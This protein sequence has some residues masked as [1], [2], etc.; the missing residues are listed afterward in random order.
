MFLKALADD[1]M[2]PIQDLRGALGYVLGEAR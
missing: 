2:V 1:S